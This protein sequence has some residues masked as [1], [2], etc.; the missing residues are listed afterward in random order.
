MAGRLKTPVLARKDEEECRR[1]AVDE[2]VR[3][4]FS[5]LPPRGVPGGRDLETAVRRA[6]A[7][8]IGALLP[9]LLDRAFDEPLL[10]ARR[11]VLLLRMEERLPP[12]V[13]PEPE[14]RAVILPL[15]IAS[16][17]AVGAL[18]GMALMPFVTWFM[19]DSRAAGL[20]MGAPA[21]AMLG[22]LA[23]MEL[24]RSRVL[25]ALF[26]S[27]LGLAAAREA[28]LL[29]GGANLSGAWYLLRKRR[30]SWKA[31]LLLPLL[32]ALLLLLG[33]REVV[34]DPVRHEEAVR[35]A[36]ASWAD[37]AA[38]IALLVASPAPQML[39][40]SEEAASLLA[41]MILP[42][43]DAPLED[44]RA[45]VSELASAARNLGFSGESPASSFIWSDEAASEYAPFGAVEP[46]DPVRIERSPL[47][48]DGELLAKGLVRRVRRR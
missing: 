28:L 14:A 29:L 46:G 24:A 38:R 3:A 12:L 47:F 48:R 45:G 4:Y 25:L 18:A 39:D 42:L 30:G 37:A 33:R 8:A 15:R 44:L 6:E 7:A 41:S 40:D 27:L 11:S 23:T 35:P 16:G 21:G 5:C 13:L 17:A 19:M 20:F 36:L 9:A 26:A 43:E 2:G 22:V 31:L 34:F 32:M 10:P 1:R